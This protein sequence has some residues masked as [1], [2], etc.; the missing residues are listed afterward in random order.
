MPTTST[1]SRDPALEAHFFWWRFRKEIVAVIVVVLLALGFL[2]LY[3]LYMD[4]RQFAAA[5]LLASARNVPDYEQLISRYPN[6]PAA[7]SGYLLL[8]EKQ[9]QEKKFTDANATLRAFIDKIPNHELAPTAEMA[10]AANLES[11]GKSDEAF[12]TYQRVA[13][14]YHQNFNAPLALISEVSLLKAKGRIDEARRVCEE[15]LMKYRMRGDQQAGAGDNRIES[16]WVSEAVRQLRLLKPSATPEPRAQPTVPP[17]LAAPP[18]AAPA[19]PPRPKPSA[20]S[21]KPRQ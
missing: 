9:R 18:S 7:A 14:K 15:V 10:I 4:R 17:M 8:A 21:N 3:R 19:V 1:V 12:A 11:M 16:F 20:T 2:G 13:T 6:T 5:S